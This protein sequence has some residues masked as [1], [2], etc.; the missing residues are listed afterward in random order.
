[1]GRPVMPLLHVGF[2]DGG[3]VFDVEGE[4][5]EVDVAC[6]GDIEAGVGGDVAVLEDDALD[7]AVGKAVDGTGRL[8][9]AG[10]VDDLT[11]RKEGNGLAGGAGGSRAMARLLQFRFISIN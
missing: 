4:A 2:G 3:A 11:L 8:R 1:M 9:V 7:G 6:V 5:G 10:D